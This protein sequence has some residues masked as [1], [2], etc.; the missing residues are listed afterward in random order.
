MWTPEFV[1]KA[2]IAQNRPQSNFI[3]QRM[4][5]YQLLLTAQ[6]MNEI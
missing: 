6:G 5:T 4:Q 2:K 3:E 1:S